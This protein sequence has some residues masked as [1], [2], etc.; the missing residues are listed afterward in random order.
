MLKVVPFVEARVG[1]PCDFPRCVGWL[2]GG[3]R[4]QLT[5]RLLIR[6]ERVLKPGEVQDLAE[7]IGEHVRILPT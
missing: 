7:V 6:S 4:P 2:S 5:L 1:V 3:F